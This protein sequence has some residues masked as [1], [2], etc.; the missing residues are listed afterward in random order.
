MEPA[1]YPYNALSQQLTVTEC[2]NRLKTVI[3]AKT[4]KQV[5]DWLGVG[6]CHYKNWKHRGIIP[7]QLI[8]PRLLQIGYSVDWLF[9]PGVQ[10]YYPR[11]VMQDPKYPMYVVDG[12]YDY[13]KFWKGMQKIEPLL[14]ANQ[15]K[16]TPHNF[17]QMMSAYHYAYEGWLS[18]DSALG[19]I[20]RAT[21]VTPVQ[22]DDCA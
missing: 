9:A 14:L 19:Y 20:A 18:I 17:E 22:H 8:V 2:M 10:L 5:V 1:Y 16:K 7:Y 11:P 4:I 13:R 6:Y 21:A 3:N 15:L 12:Q